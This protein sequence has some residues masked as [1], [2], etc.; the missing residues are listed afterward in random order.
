MAG[1]VIGLGQ[2]FSRT[3]MQTGNTAVALEGARNRERDMAQGAE[4][5]QMVGMAL[6]GAAIGAQV[7]GPPGAGVGLL[8]GLAGSLLF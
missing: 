3:A 4:K 7:A 2:D 1:G 8:A 6:S 5:Q